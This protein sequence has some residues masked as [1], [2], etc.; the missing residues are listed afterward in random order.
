ML[1]L[2]G[3][4]TILAVVIVLGLSASGELRESIGLFVEQ[5]VMRVQRLAGAKVIK[6]QRV[7]EEGEALEPAESSQSLSEEGDTVAKNS[8]EGRMGK[9]EAE[10]ERLEKDETFEPKGKNGD[11][12]RTE[13]FSALYDQAKK[14]LFEAMKILEGKGDG[15]P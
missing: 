8:S 7:E 12:S 3:F 14:S 9:D 10:D 6:A 2:I 5:G 11:R 13:E 1:R 15:N 4:L